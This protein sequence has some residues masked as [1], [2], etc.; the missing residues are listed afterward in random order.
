MSELPISQGSTPLQIPQQHDG[1]TQVAEPEPVPN[2]TREGCQT[3]LVY[4]CRAG[5]IIQFNETNDSKEYIYP[6]IEKYVFPSANTL[7]D[8]LK[9]LVHHELEQHLHEVKP[10][11]EH[12]DIDAGKRKKHCKDIIQKGFLDQRLLDG[13][14]KEKLTKQNKTEQNGNIFD[15]K[16]VINILKAL[17]IIIEYTED[18]CQGWLIPTQ[19]KNTISNLIKY[20]NNTEYCTIPASTDESSLITA[21]P[22]I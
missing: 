11:W 22:K 19:I 18:G 8:S 16:I 12:I 9:L 6:E 13:L 3:V 2:E 1:E 21:I 17:G 10:V 5:K 4:Y 14:F 7:I 15:Q 20:P